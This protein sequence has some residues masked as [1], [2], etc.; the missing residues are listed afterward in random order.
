M[1][2]PIAILLLM[3]A[4]AFGALPATTVWEIQASGTHANDSNG[5]G[6]N[7]ARGGTD[8]TQGAGQTHIDITDLVTDGAT[9][10][11]MV[12]A[13][14]NFVASD[15]GNIIS[16]TTSDSDGYAYTERFE[17]VSVASNKATVD[18]AW[19]SANNSASATKA[20]GILGGCLASPG[21]LGAILKQT[22][23]VASA[24][25][26]AGMKAYIRGGTTY[27]LSQTTVNIAGGPLD[28]DDS[29]IDSKAFYIKGYAADADDRD[30]FTGTR[31]I[32]DANGN[33]PANAAIIELKGAYNANH[34]VSFLEF[35]GDSLSTMAVAGNSYSYDFCH[36]LY[37]HDCDLT[38][39]AALKNV[40]AIH[41]RA[42]AGSSGF[43]ACH[44]YGCI[45]D[46]NSVSGFTGGNHYVNCIAYA[47]TGDGFSDFYT[48][49]ANCVSYGNGSDG[50]YCNRACQYINCISYG[51]S[52][53][54]E[55]N[56]SSE[57]VQSLMIKCAARATG[58][59]RFPVAYPPIDLGAITLTADPFTNAAGLVFSLNSAAA[60]YESLKAAGISP[61]GQ[62]GYLD[63]GAVQHA[64]PA[65]AGGETSHV[66]VR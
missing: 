43:M 22:T 35:D 47:N 27:T 4:F 51:H 7:A 62:T 11:V 9:T 49:Y 17:I 18:R 3:P 59:G 57:A 33:T 61:Y 50:F 38:L 53:G 31:P 58:S 16:V 54:Y 20:V 13:T 66:W 30:S 6:F 28:L 41:C 63:I 40:M 23:T 45:A 15:V 29:N 52:S 12:S 5:G 2:R 10:T 60:D 26:V 55:W 32:I 8:Y 14:R 42:S 46:A 34:N 37:A 24:Q 1:L 56:F 19:A 36:H 25:A 65:A 64:D 44:A 39:N 48:S 21:G